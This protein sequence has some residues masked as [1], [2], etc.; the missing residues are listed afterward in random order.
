[1][2]GD[3]L[4]FTTPA[5]TW[6]ASTGGLS[7][8]NT[9]FDVPDGYTAIGIKEVRISGTDGFAFYLS[10]DSD[11]SCY[12]TRPKYSYDSHRIN[13]SIAL[14]IESGS[15][16]MTVEADVVAV[17]K[18]GISTRNGVT[19]SVYFPQDKTYYWPANTV[20]KFS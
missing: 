1:M 19:D 7:Q 20:H 11:R 12:I 14:Y 17:K 5:I 9:T 16:V 4:I 13:T 2:G 15:A 6:T 10:D 3:V 18:D 8:K